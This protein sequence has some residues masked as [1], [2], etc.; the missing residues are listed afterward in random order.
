MNKSLEEIVKYALFL[1]YPDRK[2]GQE[3]SHILNLF[4]WASFLSNGQRIVIRQG[5]MDCTFVPSQNY[6]LTP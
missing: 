3:S 1:T 6:M 2:F 4:I 5:A